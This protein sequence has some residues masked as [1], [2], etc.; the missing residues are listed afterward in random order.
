VHFALEMPLARWP[1]RNAAHLASDYLVFQLGEDQICL[2]H[3]PS[4]RIALIARGKGPVVARADPASKTLPATA[5][6]AAPER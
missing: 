4:R 3:P 6:G 2:M 5:T 1:V